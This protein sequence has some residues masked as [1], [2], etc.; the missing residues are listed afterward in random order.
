[1]L[2]RPEIYIYN[3]VKY[4]YTLVGLVYHYVDIIYVGEVPCNIQNL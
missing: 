4:M 1:M 2:V 3:K